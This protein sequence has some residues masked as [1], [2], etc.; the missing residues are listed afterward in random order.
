[1]T[2]MQMTA[3]AMQQPSFR[4]RAFAAAAAFALA[5]LLPLLTLDLDISGRRPPD[6]LD[7]MLPGAE[8]YDLRDAFEGARDALEGARDAFDVALLLPLCAPVP[9]DVFDRA[10]PLAP[11]GL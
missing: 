9:A 7:A 6:P 2:M 3:T 1:M 4:L 11:T 10:D 5:P 8:P